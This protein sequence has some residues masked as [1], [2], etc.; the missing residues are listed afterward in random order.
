VEKEKMEKKVTSYRLSILALERLE[1][2]VEEQNDFS[3][4][5]AAEHGLKV[6]KYTKADMIEV[7]ITEK[8]LDY[9]PDEK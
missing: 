4:K 8:Y 2:I 6:S 1:K 9:F 5:F 3:Q 7:L